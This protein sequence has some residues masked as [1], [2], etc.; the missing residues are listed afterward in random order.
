ML[1]RTFISVLLAL[2]GVQAASV[3]PTGST[4]G[5]AGKASSSLKACAPHQAQYYP[6]LHA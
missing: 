2:H 4:V 3:L 6:S 5:R 1:L